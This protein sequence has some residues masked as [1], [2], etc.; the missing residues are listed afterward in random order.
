MVSRGDLA[1]LP[2]RH[3]TVHH[4]PP[5]PREPVAELDGL[6]DIGPRRCLR[7]AQGGGELADRELAH[8]ERTLP[9]EPQLTL[10][11]QQRPV[12]LRHP[13]PARSPAH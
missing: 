6:P 11:A 8:R 9:G 13:A 3:L 10:P 5:E 7:D 12:V 2:R 1:G 4:P